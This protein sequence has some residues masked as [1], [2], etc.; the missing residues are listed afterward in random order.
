MA[1][2]VGGWI[3]RV[4]RRGWEDYFYGPVGAVRFRAYGPFPAGFEVTEVRF[5]GHMTAKA[6]MYTGL[7]ISSSGDATEANYAAGISLVESTDRRWGQPLIYSNRQ[8]AYP[9]GQLLRP[10]KGSATGS[11]YVICGVEVL[12]AGAFY[13]SFGLTVERRWHEWRWAPA[14]VGAVEGKGNGV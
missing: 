8:W 3:E 10:F 7:V 6:W 14:W 9:M 12:V 5:G 2:R 4:E 1:E 11:W 13:L